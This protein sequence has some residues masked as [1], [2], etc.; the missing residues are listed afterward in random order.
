MEPAGKRNRNT[1]LL[2]SFA[3]HGGLMLLFIFLMAWRAPDPPLPEFGI[4]L[5]FGTSDTGSGDVQPDISPAS[6]VAT[7]DNTSSE[8]SEAD[9]QPDPTDAT[10]P[11]APDESEVVV[12]EEKKPEPQPSVKEKPVEK[13]KDSPK[14]K[15]TQD[16]QV[17]PAT[18][19]KGDSKSH[20][21]DPNKAGDKG[22]PQ[23]KIDAEALYGKQG[24][25]AGGDGLSLQMSGWAWADPP[26]IPDVPDNEDGR[27]VF[28]IECDADGEIIGITTLERGL[29]PRAEQLLKEEIRRNSL[30]RTSGG[31]TPERSK[32]KIVF[33]LKTR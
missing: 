15:T 7:E 14:E 19:A 18:D 33:V 20:G 25:G 24:G 23:G 8:A 30:I 13:A 1:A 26:K 9:S 4:E 10:V 6:E 22:N 31:A 17:K 27:I 32:G 12:K 11:T 3:I 29:S 28:E 5:N 16:N 2:V 21:D